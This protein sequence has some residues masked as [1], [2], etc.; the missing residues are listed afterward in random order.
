MKVFDKVKDDIRTDFTWN[1]VARLGKQGVRA[2]PAA[3][4]L[5]VLDK[6]PIIG[7][8]PRYDYKW[9]INDCVAGL[10]LAVML[11]P[12]GLAYAKIATIPVQ[13]GLM[14]AWLPAVLY[15]IM[16]TSKGTMVYCAGIR[17]NSADI[18]DR[19][20]NRTNFPDWPTHLRHCR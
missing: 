2:A 20:I 3:A 17:R 1:R 16:G 14:S 4:T 11:I 5:Y 19:S 15:T 13:W 18:H 12:Q 9:I 8:L 7:W 6:F 10:T